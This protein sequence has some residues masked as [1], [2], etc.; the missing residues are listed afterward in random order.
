VVAEA[1]DGVMAVQLVRLPVD[2]C[3]LPVLLFC[4]YQAAQYAAFARKAGAHG[5]VCKEAS[6]SELLQAVY[7]VLR[8]LVAGTSLQ[9][10]SLDLAVS[11]KTLSTYRARPLNMWVQN[12]AELMALAICHA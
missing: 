11:T 1:S 6:A 5:F 10:L 3:L 2:G 9:H 7:V 8:G 12:N 4:M